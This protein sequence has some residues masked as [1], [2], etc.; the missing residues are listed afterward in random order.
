M[1]V[2]VFVLCFQRVCLSAFV[3]CTFGCV[4]VVLCLFCV[5]RPL[6][7]AGVDFSLSQCVHTSRWLMRLVARFLAF[8]AGC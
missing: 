3:I 6:F 4:H 2:C 8:V 7:V 1:C 5:S